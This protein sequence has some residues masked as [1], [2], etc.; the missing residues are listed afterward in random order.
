MNRKREAGVR[1]D[2]GRLVTALNF[3]AEEDMGLVKAFLW[4]I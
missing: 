1:G 4:S 2:R 3:R